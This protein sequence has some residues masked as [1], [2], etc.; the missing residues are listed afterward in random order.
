M[1]DV[2]KLKIDGTN[3]DIKIPSENVKL[4][5]GYSKG[6]STNAITPSDSLN[7]AIGKLECRA[8]V[9][10][11]NVLYVLG[12][13]GKNVFD[14]NMD[15]LHSL[16][17]NGT[18][19][20][21][22]FTKYGVTFTINSDK[23]ITAVGTLTN[24]TSALILSNVISKDIAYLNGYKLSGTAGSNLITEFIVEDGTSP[25][26]SYASSSNG[27]NDTIHDLSSTS[28]Q[29]IAI[30]VRIRGSVGAAVNTTFKPMICTVEDWNVSSDYQPYMGKPNYDLTRLESEDRAS[31]AEVVDSGAKNLLKRTA[32]GSSWTDD[33]VTFTLNSDGSIT[34]NS[35]GTI[36]ANRYFAYFEGRMSDLV[37]TAGNYVLFAS[38]SPNVQAQVWWYY[39]DDWTN[40]VETP[41]NSSRYISASDLN[42]PVIVRVRA[43]AGNA[44]SNVKVYP[45]ICTE[46]AFNV[47]QKFVPYQ[48]IPKVILNSRTEFT[49]ATTMTY[50]GVSYYIPP[51][52]SVRIT[53]NL[54]N[55]HG[56]PV[57][58]AIASYANQNIYL[59]YNEMPTDKTIGANT[60]SFMYTTTDSGYTVAVLAKFSNATTN[61]VHLVVEKLN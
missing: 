40:V 38:A 6:S 54:L 49:S 7:S 21:N 25:W 52:T 46:A 55:S 10:Q 29:L 33:N 18:W 24:Q 60:V 51:N 30:F 22:T 23:S 26:Y 20:G 53:A 16:N 14:Y 5:T 15:D 35:T 42:R 2:K 34:I 13:T 48:T 37:K 27:S 45:M 43:L 4:M 44:I 11:A 31:L 28:N 19:S 39:T 61:Y 59:A 1:A 58:A 41:G 9:N 17:D 12:K 56:N 50:T 8:D 47:S 3:Y 57:E 36:T 32:I